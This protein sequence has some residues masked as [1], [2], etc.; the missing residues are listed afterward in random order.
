LVLLFFI[1]FSVSKAQGAPVFHLPVEGDM[2]CMEDTRMSSEA[3]FFTSFSLE[4]PKNG[5][6]GGYTIL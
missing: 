3:R 6:S 4:V 1:S 5:Y 2:F